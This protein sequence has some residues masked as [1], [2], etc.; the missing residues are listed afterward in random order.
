MSDVVAFSEPS[1]MQNVT[2]RDIAAE[3]ADDNSPPIDTPEESVS[4]VP[5]ADQSDPVIAV[6]PRPRNRA[7]HTIRAL[8][9]PLIALAT[10][11]YVLVAA[12]AGLAAFTVASEAAKAINA[13]LDPIIAALKRF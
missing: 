10:A 11:Q 7:S 9:K 13:A 6:P 5:D 12:I 2:M 8:L 4:L 3:R 1:S